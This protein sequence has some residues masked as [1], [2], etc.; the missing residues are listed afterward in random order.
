MRKLVHKM[1]DA[2]G[3]PRV[4]QDIDD[5]DRWWDIGMETP[6]NDK[7][8]LIDKKRVG[9]QNFHPTCATKKDYDRWWDIWIEIPMGYEPG[10]IDK[11]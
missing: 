9:E 8:G 1:A 4:E 6:E 7:P 5:Y 10:L 2:D 11:K 3:N